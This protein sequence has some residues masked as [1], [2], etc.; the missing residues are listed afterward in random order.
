MRSH[1]RPAILMSALSCLLLAGMALLV[2]ACGS[3]GGGST[4]TGPTTRPTLTCTTQTGVE[5][6]DVITAQLTCHV[7][8]AARDAT[9]FALTYRVSNSS[10]QGREIPGTCEGTLQDGAG[11][12]TQR[13]AAPAPLGVGNGIVSGWTAPD[14]QPLGPVTA[15]PNGSKSGPPLS[16]SATPRNTPTD[17]PFLNATPR[18]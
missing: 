5:G 9:S 3:A 12:C 10:G 15:Q 6:I 13:Y 4:S 16:P 17:S 2:V 18:M 7:Q 8:G 14:H 11:V 1:F